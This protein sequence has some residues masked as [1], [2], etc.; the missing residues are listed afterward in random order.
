MRAYSPPPLA[1]NIRL[2]QQLVP[3]HT[4]SVNRNGKRNPACPD[5]AFASSCPSLFQQ[6]TRRSTVGQAN[7]N[8]LCR[9]T[10]AEQVEH[11]GFRRAVRH[12]DKV[13]EHLG[14]LGTSGAPFRSADTSTTATSELH[15]AAAPSSAVG[16]HSCYP[17]LQNDDVCPHPLRK[18][19]TH[20]P[21]AFLFMIQQPEDLNGQQ[22]CH[23]YHC[24]NTKGICHDIAAE[25]FTRS[26]CKRQ[27]ECGRHRTGCNAARVK[28]NAGKNFRHKKCQTQRQQ[29]AGNAVYNRLKCRSIRAA[30]PGR[31]SRPRRWTG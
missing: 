29:I 17:P 25:C 5:N 27:Q 18:I 7:H 4:D 3:S 12:A 16:I 24:Y 2:R 15:R 19:V 26:H 23:R 1:S 9:F 6:P 28:R 22:R 30:W 13:H 11:F 31:P 14:I 21:C 8:G 20:P 10:D